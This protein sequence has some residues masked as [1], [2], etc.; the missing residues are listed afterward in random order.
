MAKH[1]RICHSASVEAAEVA[2]DA[3]LRV[4]REFTLE[5]SLERR[6]W[7]FQAQRAYAAALHKEPDRPSL[8]SK[9][10]DVWNDLGWLNRA[11]TSYL[12][13]IDLKPDDDYVVTALGVILKKLGQLEVAEPVFRRYLATESPARDPFVV[14]DVNLALGRIVA[15]KGQY[16]DAIELVKNSTDHADELLNSRLNR[17]YTGCAFQAL[18]QLYGKVGKFDEETENRIKA[19]EFDHYW[20]FA[21]E[22]AAIRA[23]RRGYFERALPFAERAVTLNESSANVALKALALLAL[24]HDEDALALLADAPLSAGVV[25]KWLGL[26][27]AVARDVVAGHYALSEKKFDE[28]EK[29]FARALRPLTVSH[30]AFLVTPY[31]DYNRSRSFLYEMALLGLAWTY[32]AQARHA[33]ALPCLDTLARVVPNN[34]FARLARVTSL[35]GLRRFGEAEVELTKLANS[36][37]DNPYVT[38]QLGILALNRGRYDDAEAAFGRAAVTGPT[39]FPCPYEGLGISYLR[40]G[41]TLEAE[42]MLARAIQVAPDRDARKYSALAK[43]RIREHRYDEAHDLLKKALENVPGHPEARKLLD[44]LNA[45]HPEAAPQPES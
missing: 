21:Q 1:L 4:S 29:R 6:W 42:K 33:E 35:T 14:A 41:K 39:A 45:A 18:G 3:Y 15:K 24:D 25:A 22:D 32:S 30:I 9:N 16:E 17:S 13:A 31:N 36:F 10:G 43:I 5:S 27:A 26:D 7:A 28:A 2:G 44:A 40:R 8:W 19:A 11:K 34:F 12:R 20:D 37:P 23:Y 38:N